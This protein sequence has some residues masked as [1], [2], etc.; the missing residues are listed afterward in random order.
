MGQAD[1]LIHE[2][3]E[4]REGSIEAKEVVLALEARRT[5]QVAHVVGGG[6]A[7]RQVV[8]N[9]VPAEML[10]LDQR[11]RELEGQFV[12]DGADGQVGGEVLSVPLPEGVGEDPTVAAER[13]LPGA[14]VRIPE[15]I[16][17]TFVEQLP[18]GLG[19]LCRE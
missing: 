16:G 2:A 12:T 14:V 5:E 13:G 8:R 17:G 1:I 11:F 19:G 15:E 18:R 4:L 6:E 7:D 10:V 3:K 9:R